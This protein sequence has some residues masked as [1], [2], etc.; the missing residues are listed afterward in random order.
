MLSFRT[1]ILIFQVV[2]TSNRNC[3]ILKNSY[4]ENDCCTD[5]DGLAPKT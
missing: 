3:H 5:N 4:T 2:F 1:I